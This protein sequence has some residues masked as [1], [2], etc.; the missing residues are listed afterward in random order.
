MGFCLEMTSKFTD[1]DIDL[2]KQLG[3]CWQPNQCAGGIHILKDDGQV[4]DS[5]IGPEDYHKAYANLAGLSGL[6]TTLS[7]CDIQKLFTGE[8]V[9]S[10]IRNDPMMSEIMS[11]SALLY[12][13]KETPGKIRPRHFKRIVAY[14]KIAF[15]VFFENEIKAG[16]M[17]PLKIDGKYD[18]QLKAA[19]AKFQTEMDIPSCVG[20]KKG[21]CMGRTVLGTLAIM[22]KYTKQ[23]LLVKLKKFKKV[24]DKRNSEK[25]YP[26]AY[27]HMGSFQKGEYAEVQQ[28][29]FETMK[30][31]GGISPNSKLVRIMDRR[32]AEAAIKKVCKRWGVIS[33]DFGS[34][35]LNIGG[36]V[37]GAVIRELEVSR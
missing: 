18:D 19:V 4:D 7:T 8:G 14:S 35:P 27:F 16:K 9:A 21:E 3:F 30:W 2:L 25:P 24:F 37:I 5:T 26:V 31:V 15:N 11:G 22:V 6:P 13:K 12:G 28:V 36:S 1:K 23:D 17:Q 10:V 33:G 29:L 32:K 34:S 20:L